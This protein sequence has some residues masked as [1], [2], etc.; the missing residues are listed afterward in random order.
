MQKEIRALLLVTAGLL[1]AGCTPSVSETE[2]QALSS[3]AS[4]LMANPV[5]HIA[6]PWPSAVASFGPSEVY[7][8]PEGVYIRT[9]GYFVEEG[10]VF[11]LDPDSSFAPSRGTDPSFEPVSGSVFTYHIRG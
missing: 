9:W 7:R 1:S 6:P 4:G 11:I 2:A 10:G 8:R 5:G 3:A